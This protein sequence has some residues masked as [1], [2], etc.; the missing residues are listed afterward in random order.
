[1]VF[2]CKKSVGTILSL[3]IVLLTLG[4]TIGGPRHSAAF[5]DEWMRSRPLEKRNSLAAQEEEITLLGKPGG[6]RAYVYRDEK[7]SPQLAI[8]GSGGLSA[9]VRVDDGSPEVKLKYK[10]GIGGKKRS[11]K[12][13]LPKETKP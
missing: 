2:S 11:L 3:A 1:M 12:E 6:P 5:T 10:I 7:G 9:D 8:G 4:C 13:T